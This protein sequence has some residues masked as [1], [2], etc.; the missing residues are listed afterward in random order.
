[1]TNR[2]KYKEEILNIAC[3]GSSIAVTKEGK[4]VACADMDCVDCEFFGSKLNCEEICIK[5]CESEYVEPP[6]EPPVDWSKVEV[7][8]K[9]LVRDNED[10]PWLKRYFAKCI[11]GRVYTWSNGK[12]SWNERWTD[13]W[14]YAKL[15]DDET[16]I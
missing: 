1:M 14:D 12:T 4:V 11:N 13:N 7:D 9:V 2:E 5:W 16:N 3:T 6:V 8:T 10:N 15:A